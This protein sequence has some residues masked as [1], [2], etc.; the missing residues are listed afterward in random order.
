MSDSEFEAIA[1][2]AETAT[3]SDF[4]ELQADAR[5]LVVECRALRSKLGRR[6]PIMG[7]GSIPWHLIARHEEQAKANHD[8]SLERLASRG[9]LDQSEAI[10]VLSDQRWRATSIPKEDRQR[11]LDELLVKEAARP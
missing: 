5:A 1:V 7:G 3:I 2:R 6:F 4:G 8:Q 10:W 9:G 11:L